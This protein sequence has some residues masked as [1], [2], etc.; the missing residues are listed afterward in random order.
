MRLLIG[1]L[2]S[3]SQILEASSCEEALE[4]TRANP[5]IRLGLLDVCLRHENG[6]DAIAA[7]KATCPD[8]VAVVV[9]ADENSATILRALDAGAMGYIPKSMSASDM[10]SALD[11]VLAG[12]I[13]LPPCMVQTQGGQM[14]SSEPPGVGRSE[15]LN[16]TA[17]QHEVLQCLLRGWPN[18]IISRHLSM[19]ENTVKTHLAAVFRGMHVTTRSQAVIAAFRLGIRADLEFS[20]KQS[21]LIA[22]Q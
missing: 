1:S 16:L 11:V 15:N 20:T 4:V 13:Y 19:S 5:D 3:D 6:L 12:G 17:R 7:V 2:Q 22:P 9:S 8:I 21:N 10:T 14:S 18:K